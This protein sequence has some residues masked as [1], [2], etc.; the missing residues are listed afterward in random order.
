MVAGDFVLCTLPVPVLRRLK[1]E[2]AFSARKQRAMAELPYNGANKVLA[3]TAHR[4]WEMDDHIFGGA[5]YTDLPT[6]FTYYPSD[7]ARAKDPRV[8]SGPGVLLVSYTIGQRAMR[9]ASQSPTVAAEYAINSLASVH[10]KLLAHGMIRK[11]VSWSWDAH[12]WS[13]G[14]FAAP[15]K[16]MD[17]RSE[18]SLPEGRIFFAGEHL[19]PHRTWIQGALESAI[20]AVE[21]IVDSA[22][23]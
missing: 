13:L 3:E 10:P 8:S 12:P 7:N 9:F 23:H 19:S 18:L 17:L 6:E 15:G 14:G 11:S 22:G 2:P 16:R 5:T 4:F 20:V 1:I 21:Q